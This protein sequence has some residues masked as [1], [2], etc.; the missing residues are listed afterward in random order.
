MKRYSFSH[1][2]I[3]AA[4]AAV[5]STS[6]MANSVVEKGFTF[7]LGGAYNWLDS[8]RQ[9]DNGLAP[10]LGIGYRFDNRWSIEGV[11]SQYRTD[12]NSKGKAK[13]KDYRVDAFYDLRPWDGS[14][15][16]YTVASAGHFTEDF[17]NFSNN[18]DTRLGLGVGVRK[19][20]MPNL[21]LRADIRA[22][23][24]LNNNN[25][26]SMAN[27]AL[28]WTF[29]SSSQPSQ[30]AIVEDQYQQPDQQAAVAPV[31]VDSDK[32]GIA[33]SQD[34]CPNSP[35]GSKVDSTGC[36]PKKSIDMR[37]QFGFDSDQISSA[38]L[39]HVAKISEFLKRYPDVRI[40]VVGYTD[41]EGTA[42]YNQNL[43]QRR[44]EKVRDLLISQ[45]GVKAD[46]IE[47]VGKGES[48]PIADN[49][50]PE[51]RQKNRRVIAEM[52]H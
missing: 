34:L 37:V 4:I 28:T 33:D 32:D 24:S 30:P 39:N 21:S 2:L 22:I 18:D 3:C 41:N 10:E 42:E 26:E 31:A 43:A 47:A 12:S 50:T 19:A 40:R 51:G 8:S 14:W 1:G 46:R 15:T 45:Y 16:P 38:E 11:Y 35:A 13:L 6:A 44:A 7:S 25:T 52:L 48:D 5:V 27:V 49:T 29:G 23:R 9:L 17:D 36:I 20:L